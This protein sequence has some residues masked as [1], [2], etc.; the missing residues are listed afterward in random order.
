MNMHGI[1]TPVPDALDT[2]PS[3]W[4][5]LRQWAR[6][7]RN[8]LL[9]VVLPTVLLAGY[10]FLVAADQYQSEAH[11]IVR[12]SE[13]SPTVPSGLGQVLGMAGGFSPTQTEAM[14]VSDYL[15]SNDAVETLRRKLDLVARF[16]RPEADFYSRLG[17]A[18]PT[19]ERLLKYYRGQVGVNYNTDTGITTLTVRAFRPADS[20]AIIQ[21]LLQLGER[22]VNELNVRSY[23]DT[24]A[25]SRRQLADAERAVA[26]IQKRLTGFRQASAD[27]DPAGSGQAQ[28]GLVSSLQAQL[29]AS[30]AQLAAMRGAISPRS[31]QYIALAHETQSL[32]R[33]VA[34]QAAKI[35]GTGGT[36]IA[37]D[38]GGYEDL[39][40]R[41]QFAAKQYEAA[42]A[43][44]EKAREQAQRQQ[45]YIVRVV[46]PS[47][48]VKS[49]YP[50]RWRILATVVIALL[51]VHAI[52]WL[53]AAGM[54]EHAA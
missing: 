29:S 49:L 42:A 31:P 37:N 3:R 54:R 11:F 7:R 26:S 32:E 45:L 8:F 34:A 2:G 52:S 27:I 15:S 13:S 14:S 17:S 48:P 46:D 41:Q 24:L 18:D 35:A 9:I 51:L 10:L 36:T 5:R 38:L 25:S 39:R 23:T 53:I 33:E 50:E 12:G 22:R 28:I 47:M 19:P 21:M 4:T 43:A 6:V 20:Y 16:R 30:R 1:F 44:V 40:I